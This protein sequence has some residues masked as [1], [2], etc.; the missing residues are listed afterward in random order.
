VDVRASGR[1]RLGDSRQRLL[2]VDQHLQ[3]VARARRRIAGGPQRLADRRVEL[4][5]ASCAFEAETVVRADGDLDGAA[6]QSVD[7]LDWSDAHLREPIPTAT[8]G[9]ADV[10][11]WLASAPWANCRQCV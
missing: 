4:F 6:C 7:A 1:E 3:R 10:C 5:Q 11:E 2:A 8:V 9:R